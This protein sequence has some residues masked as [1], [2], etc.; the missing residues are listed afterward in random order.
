M[1]QDAR[2]MMRTFLREEARWEHL[3]RYG[4]LL[5]R[6]PVLLDFLKIENELT[7]AAGPP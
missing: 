4:E 3:S 7:E 1:Q 6:Y 5:T 2:D